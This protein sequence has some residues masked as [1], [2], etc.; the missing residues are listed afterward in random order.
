MAPPIQ[1]FIITFFSAADTVAP[2]RRHLE[3]S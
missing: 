2:R 1:V 3:F